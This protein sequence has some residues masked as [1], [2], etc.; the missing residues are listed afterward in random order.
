VSAHLD[1]RTIATQQR[2]LAL[3]MLILNIALPIDLVV[4]ALI[5]KQD[6]RHY[7]DIGLILMAT[8]LCVSVGMSASGVDPYGGKR[9]NALWIILVIAVVVPVELTL[10][11]MVDTPTE[12]I[13][14][15]IA[16]A[17]SAFLMLGILRGIYRMWERATLGRAAREE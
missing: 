2:W 6:P 15:I 9:S 11:G 12:F 17:A 16:T 14:I 3:G 8:I 5:L 1:E 4:R 13:A 10:T 7:L